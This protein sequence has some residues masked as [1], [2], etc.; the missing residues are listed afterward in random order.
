MKPAHALRCAL[1][2]TLLGGLSAPAFA[3]QPILKCVLL[4]ESTVRCRAGTDEGDVPGPD[5]NIEVIDYTGKTLLSRKIGRNVILTFA[6]PAIGYYVLF[7]VGPG[8]Q[9]IVEHDEIRPPRSTDKAR[10]VR[11]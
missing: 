9:A 8:Y 1:G 7:D 10:W 4:D 2:L 11:K 3:H 6:R 5:A